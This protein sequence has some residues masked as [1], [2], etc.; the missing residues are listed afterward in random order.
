MIYRIVPK[1]VWT[2]AQEDIP[3]APIDV[4]DG[5]IHLSSKETVLE[6]AN[7]YFT[8][9]QEPIVLCFEEAELGGALRWEK[10]DVRGGALFPHLYAP[11]L[12]CTQIVEVQEL[13]RVED[14]FLWGKSLFVRS[15]I[16]Q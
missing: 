14:H 2:E 5:Y 6:T 1:K 15:N 3:L 7:L 16:S 9:E 13:I 11:S 4:Q 8:V 10:V 12:R